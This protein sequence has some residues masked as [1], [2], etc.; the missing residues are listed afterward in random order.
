MDGGTAADET[1]RIRAIGV[2]PNSLTFSPEAKTTQAAPSL[3]PEEFP[4]VTLPFDVKADDNF[5]NWSV[6]VSRGC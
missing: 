3:M 5:C 2:N 6:V 4:A 1:D